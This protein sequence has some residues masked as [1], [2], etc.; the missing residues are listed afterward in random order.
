M[1]GGGE[2][3]DKGK[4]Q[5]AMWGGQ[6]GKKGKGERRKEEIGI[7]SLSLQVH[8]GIPEFKGYL[9]LPGISRWSNMSMDNRSQDC[10]IKTD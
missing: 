5:K 9:L 8:S 7:S 2:G 1:E 6:R 3:A 10:L 4:G